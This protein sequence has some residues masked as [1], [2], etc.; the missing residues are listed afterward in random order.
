MGNADANFEDDAEAAMEDAELSSE[1]RGFAGGGSHDAAAG[2]E[3]PDGR[4]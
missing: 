3:D 1:L 4:L 2:G